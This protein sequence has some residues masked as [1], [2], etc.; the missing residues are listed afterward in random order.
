MLLRFPCFAVLLFCCSAPA[1]ADQ[2]PATTK[3]NE[4]K[5][6]EPRA[7]AVPDVL[8]QYNYAEQ[9]SAMTDAADASETPVIPDISSSTPMC[10][11]G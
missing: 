8:K 4:P 1:F 7:A 2:P 6:T 3:K 10:S 9:V 11:R 5:R